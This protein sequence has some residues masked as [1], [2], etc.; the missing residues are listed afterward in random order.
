MDAAPVA[1]AALSGLSAAG[2]LALVPLF[3]LLRARSAGESLRAR[4]MFF[5]ATLG[6]VMTGIAVL[7][8]I[9][10]IAPAY[11]APAIAL[12][13]LF[14]TVATLGIAG[15]PLGRQLIYAL[16]LTAAVF[17]PIVSVVL[18]LWWDP[19]ATGLGYL[20][21]GV[22]LPIVIAAACATL[23]TLVVA[24]VVDRARPQPVRLGTGSLGLVAAIWLA[25]LAWLLGLQLGIDPVAGLIVINTVVMPIA[26]VATA[27]LVERLRRRRN[28]ISGVVFGALGGLAAAA[29]TAAYLITPV[30]LVVGLLAGMLVAFLPEGGAARRI[31]ATLLVAG[32][33]GILLLGLVAKDVSFI[34][35]GQPEV[36]FG[37]VLAVILAGIAGFGVAAL[38][39]LALR[40]RR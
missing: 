40:P 29:P 35:T 19:F 39:W 30:A 20:D 1:T 16:V 33:S 3:A 5:V 6:A 31:A 27:A 13:A 12:G 14:A 15:A 7:T 34:Y 38:L 26:A 8:G 32:G 10:G 18:T 11:I 4:R 17:V 22:A 2:I 28:T 24:R 21:F 36:L 37:Q 25:W 9:T 23:G